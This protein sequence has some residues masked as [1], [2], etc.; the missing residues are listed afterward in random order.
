M[1]VDESGSDNQ[2]SSVDYLP[3][4]TPLDFTELTDSGNRIAM[5]SK[6]GREASRAGSV[7][8]NSVENDQVKRGGRRL[9][10]S[11]QAQ[12]SQ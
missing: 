6:I 12:R 3:G 1:N 10:E 5:D 2:A 9:T 11:A 8:H 7:H 4:S